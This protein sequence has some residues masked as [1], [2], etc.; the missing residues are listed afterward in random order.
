MWLEL[1]E[2]RADAVD[3]DAVLCGQVLHAVEFVDG[4]V[5]AAVG[6]LGIA[7]DVADAVAGEVLQMR[8]VGGRALA[9]ELHQHRLFDVRGAL[10]SGFAILA[11]C[12]ERGSGCCC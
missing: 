10:G 4:G 2:R 12:A 8:V 3:L 6:D 11:R 7:A 5:E 9:A 1:E